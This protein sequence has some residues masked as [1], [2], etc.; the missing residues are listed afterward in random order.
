MDALSSLTFSLHENIFLHLT[1]RSI[2]DESAS[3]LASSVN[4]SQRRINNFC[5]SGSF[6]PRRFFCCSW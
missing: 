1:P 4:P 5:I 2:A 6:N 3:S